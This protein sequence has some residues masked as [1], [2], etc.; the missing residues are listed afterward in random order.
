MGLP[1]KETGG[2][3]LIA[4][5]RGSLRCGLQ[6]LLEASPAVRSLQVVESLSDVGQSLHNGPPDLVLLA[7]SGADQW[8]RSLLCEIR[9]EYPEIVL[10]ALLADADPPLLCEADAVYTQGIAPGLLL[11]A[12]ERLLHSGS[13][14]RTKSD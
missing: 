8:V 10:V 3:V 5:E 12:L 4:T 6:A 7:S 9:M 2:R 13:Q 1:R 14:N 11:D